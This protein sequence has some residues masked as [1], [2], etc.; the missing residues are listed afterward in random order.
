VNAR[1]TG[2]RI[3]IAHAI[4]RLRAIIM[5]IE[6][7]LDVDAPPGPDV[8]QAVAHAGVDL[9]CSI[10]RLEAYMRA[11]D[12]ELM[13]FR[14]RAAGPGSEPAA[15]ERIVHLRKGTRKPFRL[16]RDP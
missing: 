15:V 12:D 9:A 16:E 10:A 3:R 11:D 7:T 1:A 5:Q 6:V 14:R 13:D 8:G 2:E 4:V